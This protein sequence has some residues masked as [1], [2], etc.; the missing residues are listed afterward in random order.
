MPGRGLFCASGKH[1]ARPGEPPGRGTAGT[2]V[3]R[4]LQRHRQETGLPAEGRRGG[5]SAQS[6]SWWV[7]L[8][9]YLV[10]CCPLHDLDPGLAAAAPHPEGCVET[11]CAAGGPGGLGRPWEGTRPPPRAPAARRPRG[12][13]E[14]SLSLPCPS[15]RPTAPGLGPAA[16]AGE[17]VAWLVQPSPVRAELRDGG[18]HERRGCH[19][20]PAPQPCGQ[21]Q[22]AG[23]SGSHANPASGVRTRAARQGG[24]G[25]SGA[26][27]PA[28]AP[29]A[30]AG[31]GPGTTEPPLGA[32]SAAGVFGA[33]RGRG[34]PG[35]GA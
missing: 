20:V 9:C 11:T 23:V 29:S 26:P 10:S 16:R 24:A 32:R 6:G 31:K 4:R 35:G 25:P 14:T 2:Q 33:P 8:P 5:R 12:G 21:G 19:P 34:V 13:R 17:E 30:C 28:C 1:T 22:A 15:P 7:D 18:P 3:S 27:S